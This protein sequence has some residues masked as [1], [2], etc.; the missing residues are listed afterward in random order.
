MSQSL[1]PWVD[2]STALDLSQLRLAKKLPHLRVVPSAPEC[3]EIDEEQVESYAA[4]QQKNYEGILFFAIKALSV[5]ILLCCMTIA[6]LGIGFVLSDTPQAIIVQS[7]D[8]LYSIG[9]SLPDA[10]SPAQAAADIRSLNALDSDVLY[11]GQKLIL[12]QY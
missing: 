9:A 10:P 8:S 11:A 7:G 1:A 4:E 6:G 12:P 5:L 3:V 2:G